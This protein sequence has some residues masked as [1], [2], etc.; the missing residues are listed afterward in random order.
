VS[1]EVLAEERVLYRELMEA[2][3]QLPERQREAIGLRQSGLSFQ[4]VGG[5]MSCSE[6]AAKMLYHRALRSLRGLLP[7]AA[8]QPPEGTQR[9]GGSSG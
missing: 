9:P 4:E 7:P 2:V 3:S 6:D 8:S 1:P 5:L